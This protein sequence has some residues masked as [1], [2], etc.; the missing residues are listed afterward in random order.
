[1]T[2]SSLAPIIL[3][4][5]V[6]CLATAC[7]APALANQQS[8]ISNQQFLLTPRR[9][10]SAAWLDGKV[11][12]TGGWNGQATQL[13]VV[14]ALDP[15]SMRWRAAPALR[16][17]RSQH[18]TISADNALWIIGGWSADGG[19]I[20]EVERYRSG[21]REWHMVTRLPTPRREP[22]VALL[23]RRIVV[24]GG[25]DG[26][27][28]ADLDGYNGTVEAYDLDMQQWR[29]LPSLRHPRRGLVLVALDDSLYAIGGFAAGEG[30]LNTV[31]RYDAANERWQELTWPLAPRTWAAA[32]VV[33]GRIILSGGYNRSGFLG[34][35]E[36]IDPN[37]G[38]VCWPPAL[39][40]PRAW[41]AAVPF[42][43]GVLAMGGEEANG[44]GNTVEELDV[45]CH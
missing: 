41:L 35:V 5:L 28:D 29:T 33:S 2:R 13:N 16:Q 23:G 38:S 26:S 11:Y 45:A 1:M 12:A 36:S 10:F 44:Y 15:A 4:V 7:A 27:G 34:L 21:D 17:A 6:A 9:A 42:G 20:R 24:A 22:G 25:F 40:T 37:T 18:A 14:E 8:T 39:R 3:F 31:E 19:L 30:F 32:A 43:N